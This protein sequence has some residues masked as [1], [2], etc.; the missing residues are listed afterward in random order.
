[1]LQEDVGATIE[2]NK[3]RLNSL[4][5]ADQAS[6]PVLELSA[7]WNLI[8]TEWE[9]FE[10]PEPVPPIPDMTRSV[11]ETVE[12]SCDLLLSKSTYA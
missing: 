1:M 11:S 10:P 2:K 3:E 12:L 8:Q 6:A 9:T 7:W 5:A 4:K